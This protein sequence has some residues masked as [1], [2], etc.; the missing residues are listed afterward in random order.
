MT[1]RP[2]SAADAAAVAAVEAVATLNPWTER[3]VGEVLAAPSTVGFVAVDGAGAIIGHLLASVAAGEGE[4]LTLAVEPSARRRGVGRALIG[5]CEARWRALGVDAAWL[6]VRADN[7]AARALYAERGWLDAG[8][9]RGYY[10]DG[11]DAA[12]MRWEARPG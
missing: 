3:S 8:V 6:E 4:I 7:V 5:A 9:R 11:V 10:H 2:A 12:L 1:V